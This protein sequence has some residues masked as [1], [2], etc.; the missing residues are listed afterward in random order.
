MKIL[1]ISIYPPKNEKHANTGGAAWYT[2]NLITH[3]PIGANDQV[4][5]LCDKINGEYEK[6]IE[7]NITVIRCFDKKPKY[8]YQLSKEISKINPDIIHIQQELSLYGNILTAYLLQ[9]FIF[10]FRQ[11]KTIIT[12]HGVVSLK[13]I[14]KNFIKE[15]NSNL[16]VWIT[17]VAFR[18]IYNPLCFWA[19]KV[20]VHEECFKNILT[21]EYG[22]NQ[23]KTEVIHIG[24][25]DS[26]TIEKE[27]AC[28]ELRIDS[29][30]DICLFMG[31]LAGY[32]GIDLLIEGFA[33]YGKINRNA[34]LVIGAGKHPKLRNDE[35]YL[36]EYKRL[37]D[38]A[39][40]LIPENQ[41]RWIGFID[42]KNIIL[43]Y[44]ASDVSLYPYTVS[45][46][47][48]GPM[49][50]AIGYE[51]PFLASEVFNNVLSEKMLF[52]R[53]PKSLA[54]KLEDFFKDQECFQK[55]IAEMKANRLLKNIGVTTYNIYS[56][57]S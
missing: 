56:N 10:R 28:K 42:E 33:E 6:Y 46:S 48:S 24:V 29:K 14:D 40:E 8:V 53:N 31:Y 7:N 52:Q 17:K 12:L 50:I 34:V 13:K 41:C 18:I 38:K 21:E 39:K 32:K 3:T 57:K 15:N 2:K 37:E 51:K 35:K 22:T 55:D 4:F 19:Q 23:D 30:N 11:Y 36:K 45:M 49:S 27:R 47:S 9:W 54:K 20:I 43:Y 5:V 44:S 25:E 1:H 26:Q 16:P